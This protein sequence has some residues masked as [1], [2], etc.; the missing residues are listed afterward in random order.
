MTY[1]QLTS[2]ERYMIQA[3]KLQGCPKAEIARKLN[4]HR[5]TIGRELK[6]NTYRRGYDPRDAI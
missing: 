3:L 6:R 2:R 1:H 4:R 5:C